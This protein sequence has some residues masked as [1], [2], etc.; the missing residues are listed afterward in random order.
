MSRLKLERPIVFFDL[1]T[2]GLDVVS[3]RIVQ[4]AMLKVC[5]DDSE[6]SWKTLV[7]PECHIPE[8][9]TEI[10]GITDED[11]KEVPTFKEIGKRVAAFIEN[12][13]LAGYN[14]NRFDVPMLAEELLRASIPVDFSQRKVIDVQVIFHKMEPRTLSAAYL[15]YTGNPLDDAH[16]AGADT[17]ATYEVLRG[18]LNMYP[19]LT[20]EVEWLHSFTRQKNFVDLAG[21]MSYNDRN[22]PCFNFGKYRGQSVVKVFKQDGAYYGWLMGNSFPRET[23]MHFQKLMIEASRP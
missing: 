1:E 18:Q 11:V 21:R 19:A 12:C 10:H 22:E 5:P 15:F 9:S 4:I 23:K 3:D 8:S 2:T 6:E 20:P 16:D 17:R 13:D 7:N 14:C